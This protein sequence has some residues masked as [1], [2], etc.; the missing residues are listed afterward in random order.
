MLD[1]HRLRLLREFRR[2][3][4]IAAVAEALSYSPS[5]VSHQLSELQI[6][7]G[8]TLL[9]RDGR[10]L[11]LTEAGHVLARHADVLLAHVERAEAEMASAAGAVAGVVRIAAFQT[12]AVHL[13]APALAALARDHQALRG[14]ITELESD[15][16]LDALLRR[17]ADLAICDDYD[18]RPLRR[19]RGL[20]VED[21]YAESVRLVLPRG[22]PAR[23]L[24]DVAGAQWAGG[25]RG[26]SHERLIQDVC[27]AKGGFHADIKHRATDLLVLLALVGAG[28][29][30]TLLPDLAR[31]EREGSVETLDIGVGRRIFTVV[32]DDGLAR[33]ALAAVRAALRAA[34]GSAR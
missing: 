33:P 7:A 27:A 25:H 14:E 17:E 13:A 28:Q 31:P 19:L 21:L 34:A 6:E 9:E 22:H 26:T 23:Q 20:T 2:R 11:R 15:Q 5:T 30:V 8:V 12:A 24:A 29:A 18:G 4:T 32:R 1:L 3:G 10:R 16:A